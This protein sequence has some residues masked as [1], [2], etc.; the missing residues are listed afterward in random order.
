M[1][2]GSCPE[3]MCVWE[4]VESLGTCGIELKPSLVPEH[5]LKLYPPITQNS[6]GGHVCWSKESETLGH[7]GNI[8]AFSCTSETLRKILW[9]KHCTE[10]GSRLVSAITSC[11]L[12]SCLLFS[13]GPTASAL[14]QIGGGI[15]CCHHSS[16]LLWRP[17]ITA[18]SVPADSAPPLGHFCTGQEVSGMVSWPFFI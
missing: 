7:F 10:P 11:S 13:N 17:A 4:E 9:H 14:G 8:S 5:L 18:F 3:L 12:H 6:Q 15:L 2:L 1:A 16:S